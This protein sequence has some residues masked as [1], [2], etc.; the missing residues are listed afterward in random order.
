M[1]KALILIGG[2]STRMGTDKYLM[3][4]DGIPQYQRLHQLLQTLGLEVYLSCNQTQQDSI[5]TEYR[6]IIDV[7]EGIGPM[8][9]LASALDADPDSDWLVVACDLINVQAETIRRLLEPETSDI[10]VITYKDPKSGFYETTITLYKHSVQPLVR[11]ALEEKRY[12][13]Q[14]VLKKGKVHVILPG[15]Y[16]ELKNVNKPEDLV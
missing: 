13:L 16:T 6:K 9:G 15:D 8:G 7:Y 14:G 10:D 3:E 1:S 4:V 5:S 12:S 2:K 11:A